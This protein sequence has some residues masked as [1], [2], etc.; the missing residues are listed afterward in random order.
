MD[1]RKKREE[2]IYL[3][4]QSPELALER[5]NALIAERPDEIWTWSLRS[6]VYETKG[7]F[8]KAFSDINKAINIEFNEPDL[9]FHKAR[10]FL[11]LEDYYSAL[12]SFSDAINIG[13]D[14]HFSYY[15]GTCRFMRA[16]CYCK[17]GDFEAAEPDLAK[18]EDYMVCWIDRLRTKAELLEACRNR[19]ID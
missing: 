8:E 11:K 13:E 18:V 1:I 7:D 12:I 4:R 5:A 14:L 15:D 3:A 9:H 10:Y 19:Q 16:L 17:I 6:Y 2:I